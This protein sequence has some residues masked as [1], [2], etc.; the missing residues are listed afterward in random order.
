VLIDGR[1]SWELLNVQFWRTMIAIALHFTS[2]LVLN[3]LS[4]K[5][6]FL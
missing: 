4:L 1:I 5:L 3:S 6:G 2:I